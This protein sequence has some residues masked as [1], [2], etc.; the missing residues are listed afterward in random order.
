[1]PRIADFKRLYPGFNLNLFAQE[2]QL[3]LVTNHIDAAIFMIR[4][5]WLMCIAKDCLVK[6]TS[7]SVHLS[8]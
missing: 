8:T 2:N 1:M 6:S 7:R 4:N 3:D 5:I